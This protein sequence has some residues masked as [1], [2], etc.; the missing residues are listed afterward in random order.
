[1]I[2]V[3]PEQPERASTAVVQNILISPATRQSTRK[4][5]RRNR[6]WNSSLFRMGLMLLLMFLLITATEGFKDWSEITHQMYTPDCNLQPQMSIYMMSGKEL[7]PS[8]KMKRNLT[9][10]QEV[11]NIREGDVH[12]VRNTN[13]AGVCLNG[14]LSMLEVLHHQSNMMS[15][16]ELFP[17]H[18][19]ECNLTRN[20]GVC[21]IKDGDVHK[22]GDTNLAGVCLKGKLSMLEVLHHQS[23]VRGP[24]AKCAHQD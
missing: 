12:K 2:A 16:K 3:L 7:F 6:S 8:H 11:C 18:E 13:L 24:R 19:M 17:S 5:R 15:G 1:M 9:R 22:V 20:Q 23:N 10:N 4:T 14:K 21:N